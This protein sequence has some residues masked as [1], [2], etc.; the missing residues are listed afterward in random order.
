MLRLAGRAS[1][2]LTHAALIGMVARRKGAIVN[3]SWVAAFGKSSGSVS[4]CATKAWMNAFTEG[5][6]MEL[7]SARSAARVQALCPVYT[8]TQFHDTFG[9]YRHRIP[10][11]L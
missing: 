3:V 11:D 9:F 8:I 6:D 2:R 5:L 10:N 4:Y 7:K 1:M